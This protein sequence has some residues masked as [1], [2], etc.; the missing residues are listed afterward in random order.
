MVLVIYALLAFVEVSFT[1]FTVADSYRS[2]CNFCCL[3]RRIWCLWWNNALP[4]TPTKD[5]PSKK[6]CRNCAFCRRSID[7]K[8]FLRLLRL[9]CLNDFRLLGNIL[10]VAHML[11]DCMRLF[12]F[13]WMLCNRWDHLTQEAN[14]RRLG[15]KVLKTIAQSPSFRFSL[16]SQIISFSSTFLHF[17]PAM[18]AMD[19][20]ILPADILGELCS[21]LLDDLKA[22]IGLS[23]VRK[24][25]RQL[26]L[27]AP[28]KDSIW[29]AVCLNSWAIVDEELYQPQLIPRGLY[30]EE[31]KRQEI[32]WHE[33]AV[34]YSLLFWMIDWLPTFK[35]HEQWQFY[36]MQK[37]GG[38]DFLLILVTRENLPSNSVVPSKWE[39][40]NGCMTWTCGRQPYSCSCRLWDSLRICCLTFEAH[41]KKLTII[42]SAAA[43]LRVLV[44]WNLFL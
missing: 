38:D 9:C 42:L 28:L 43:H 44:I 23:G 21:Y 33:G 25:W 39:L 18:M 7:F 1:R 11:R 34:P 8:R 37:H 14:I 24:R 10:L 41:K 4:S 22:L 36:A 20:S 35:T 17:P 15:Q 40:P 26:M 5:L 32:D 6:C 29:R 27:E 16:V 30:Y 19:P 31:P 13:Y 3:L 12:A 2:Q